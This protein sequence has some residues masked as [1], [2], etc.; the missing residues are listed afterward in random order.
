MELHHFSD[1]SSSAYEAVSYLKIDDGDGGEWCNLVFSRS[2]AAPTEQ[3]T[4]PQP[5]LA[6]ATLSVQ[7]DEMLNREVSIS[8]TDSFYWTIVL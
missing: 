3:M 2:R 4:M 7:Q 8:V 5:E 6:A 1:A